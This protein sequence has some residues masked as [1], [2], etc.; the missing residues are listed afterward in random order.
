[1]I[2][3]LLESKILGDVGTAEE[4]LQTAVLVLKSQLVFFYSEYDR[5]HAKT[6]TRVSDLT[7]KMVG[8]R[9]QPKCK[10][11]GAETLGMAFFLQETL[12]RY[13]VQLG[14]VGRRFHRGGNAILR[15]VELWD[16]SPFVMDADVRQDSGYSFP[17]CGE[18]YIREISS[19]T[20]PPCHTPPK[21]ETNFVT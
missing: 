5:T 9:N 13:A 17:M 12:R 4:N 19:P 10:T 15:M 20:C 3:V 2:W 8:T 7:S 16:I 1:M 18:V 21:L 6:L 14:D 11:K